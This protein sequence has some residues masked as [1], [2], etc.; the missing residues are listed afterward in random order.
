MNKNGDGNGSARSSRGGGRGIDDEGQR[1][2]AAGGRGGRRR[3]VLGTVEGHLDVGGHVG[4]QK[5]P[6]R[7]ASTR[8]PAASSPESSWTFASVRRHLRRTHASP[9]E[10]WPADS[11]WLGISHLPTTC[12][13]PHQFRTTLAMDISTLRSSVFCFRKWLEL[14]SVQVNVPKNSLTPRLG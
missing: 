6:N 13:P 12:K 5:M 14:W 2:A 4:V 11:D 3:R 10:H 7:G 8:L 1:R 9:L